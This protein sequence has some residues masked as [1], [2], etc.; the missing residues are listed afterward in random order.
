[1]FITQ[2]FNTAILLILVNA[3]FEE[4]GLPLAT[5][6]DGP[7]RDFTP[8]WYTNV[9]YRVTQTMLINAF[10][11]YIEFT[12]AYVKLN[13]FRWKDRSFGSD[14]YKTQKTSIQTYIDVYSGPEYMIHFKYSGMLNVTFVTMLYGMGIPILF[15]IAALTY[16]N[17][18]T[19]ERLATTYFY[20]LPPTF[21]D[22]LTKNAVKIIRFAPLV[23][24]FFGYWM[25]SNKQIF[26][27]MAKYI[28][29]TNEIPLTFHTFG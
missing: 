4:V 21:D 5:V 8:T 23:Y 12:I 26:T 18:Y 3:N 19:L 20:Q 27:D 11:P 14:T 9:G 13:L 6:F 25:L 22:K 1:M 15:P 17:L 10:F 16:F 7:F 24:L 2:F 29:Y 28:L